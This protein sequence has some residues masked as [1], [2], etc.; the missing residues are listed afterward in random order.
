VKNLNKW[1][2]VYFFVFVAILMLWLHL[3]VPY[4]GLGGLLFA[5]F[6]YLLVIH[7]AFITLA[8]SIGLVAYIVVAVVEKL[9]RN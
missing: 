1:S 9:Q 8:G 3:T 7:L 4:L 6:A 2:G 5:T